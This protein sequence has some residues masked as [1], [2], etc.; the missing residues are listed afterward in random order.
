MFILYSKIG[1]VAIFA[2]M[3]VLVL[4]QRPRLTAVFARHPAPY[5][6]L[7]WV[8]FRLLPFVV[9]YLIFGQSPQSDLLH[10]F[11]PL[12]KVILQGGLPYRD[13]Q[14]PYSP[15]FSTLMAIPVLV[16]RDPRSVLLFLLLA[17]GVIVWFTFRHFKQAEPVPQRMF[18]CLF[19][20]TLPVPFAMSV[21]SGQEDAL[22]W[23]FA[24]W[25]LIFVAKR[26]YLSGLLLGLGLL[27]T[28]AILMFVV[29]PLLVITRNRLAFLAGLC[30]LTVPVALFLTW[31]IQWL[32]ITQPLNE[33]SFMK[34][35][36]WR[37]LLNPVLPEPLLNA[38]GLW[39][40]AGIG[41]LLSLTG[42]LSAVGRYVPGQRLLPLFF[43][44]VYGIMSVVQQSAISTYSYIFML[45]LVFT[46]TD[47]RRWWFCLGLI[48]FNSLAAIHPS[49]WWRL[50][51]PYY[52]WADLLKPV[53][54]LE[55]VIEIL[56]V[57]GFIYYALHAMNALR[58]PE[59][60]PV[61]RPEPYAV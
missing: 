39:K 9:I 41:L 35:P 32:W 8:L 27:T 7:F 4:W 54:A 57:A 42:W 40:W 43:I 24:A 37:S 2:I 45:P 34:A 17:E 11:Y 16:W 47:F 28:K 52:G 21:L 46:L 29:V 61:A 60:E 38:T 3:A 20:Y 19:Y 10:F 44:A 12:G 36:N 53:A 48:G 58:R 14:S 26:P 49:L 1:L 56:I 5:L 18:R 25:A 22:M 30:T 33:G 15:L 23:G 6:A 31:Q 51:Q 55:Y 50:G 13:A 59:P